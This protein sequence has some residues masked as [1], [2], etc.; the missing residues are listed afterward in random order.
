MGTISAQ[1]SDKGQVEQLEIEVTIVLPLVQWLRIVKA[2]EA[3]T[4]SHYGP[5]KDVHQA[6]TKVIRNVD[7]QFTGDVMVKKE[8]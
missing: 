4:E 6:I 1:L 8:D 2:L 5:V 7:R 3:S